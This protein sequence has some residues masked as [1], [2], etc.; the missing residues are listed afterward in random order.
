MPDI[1]KAREDVRFFSWEDTNRVDD[2][3]T[4]TGS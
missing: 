3:R 2:L 4:A 1:P